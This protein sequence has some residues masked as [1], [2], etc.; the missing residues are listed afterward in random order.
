MYQNRAD[1]LVFDWV[2]LKGH[3]TII[4]NGVLREECRSMCSNPFNW[5]WCF[6]SSNLIDG[7]CCL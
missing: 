6:D 1:G 2:A 5:S 3:G 7:Y 4:I